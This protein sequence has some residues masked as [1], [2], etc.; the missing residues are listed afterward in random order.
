MDINLTEEQKKAALEAGKQGMKNAY[1]K[2]G[3]R[4]GL[5]WWERLLWVVLAGAAYVASSL[6]SGCGYTVDVTAERAEICRDD[7]CLVLEPG[8][9]SCFQKQPKTEMPP[10]IQKIRQGK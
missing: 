7:S 2:S 1:E 8:H 9:L 5:T 3:T 10:V 4:P 6:L